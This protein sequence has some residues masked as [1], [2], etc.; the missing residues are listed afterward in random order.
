M[1]FYLLCLE[2]DQQVILVD[3]IP[4][5]STILVM[6]IELDFQIMARCSLELPIINSNVEKSKMAE[7]IKGWMYNMQKVLC[8]S[9][10]KAL[11]IKHH[12]YSEQI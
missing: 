5:T 11:L 7:S 9:L 8:M 6:K 12:V 4:Y 3:S 1:I 2:P 10:C